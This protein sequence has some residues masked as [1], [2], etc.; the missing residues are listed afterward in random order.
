[1]YHFF[2]T[3][4]IEDGIAQNVDYHQRRM[5]NTIRLKLGPSS[6]PRLTEIISVP[7]SYTQGIVK[8]KIEYTSQDYHMSFDHYS[9]RTVKSLKLI[10]CDSINY[11]H[12]YSNRK[13]LNDLFDKRANCD[14]ILI[15]KNSR[16]TDTSF[17]NIALFD[18]YSWYTPDSPLLPGTA[19][20]R[21]IDSGEL[22]ERMI[23]VKNLKEFQ[24][25][26]LINSMLDN[27]FSNK[28]SVVTILK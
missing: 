16:I 22:K 9:P 25:Y 10:Y 26:T 1:M 13:Q 18:G 20:A 2:E 11:D 24:A 19:R 4:R 15:V 5:D 21:M 14:D 8:C 17:S 7:E 27:N 28:N 12:K 23:S 6:L 3:I